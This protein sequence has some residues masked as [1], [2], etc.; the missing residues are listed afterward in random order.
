MKKYIAVIMS[1]VVALSLVACGEKAVDNKTNT[2]NKDNKQDVVSLASTYTNR[3]TN[4]DQKALLEEIAK[5][6]GVTVVATTN[7]D[8]TPNIAI[9]TPAAAGDNHIVFNLAPNTTKD[10]VLREK[11]AE[12]VFDKT[13]PTA[14]TKQERHQGAVVKLALEEDQ[15]VIEELK[16]S[17]DFISDISLVCKIVEVMPIG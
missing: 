17:N 9:F 2:D 4:L 5:Y 13:N 16:K 15:Q 1:A 10:N 14:E 7:V 6:S 8:G 11:V 12:M 3:Y